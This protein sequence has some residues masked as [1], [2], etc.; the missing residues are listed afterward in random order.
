MIRRL[1]LSL[2][3]A[4]ALVAIAQDQRLQVF[5]LSQRPAEDL[6][7]AIRPLVGAG[8]A[9]TASGSKLIVNASP[10]AL[11]EIAR[12]VR[13]LDVPARSL[14]IT[15]ERQATG[16]DQRS[17]GEVSGRVDAG[18]VTVTRPPTTTV[19]RSGTSVETRTGRTVVTG[20]FAGGSVESASDTAFRIRALDGRPAFIAVGG[21]RPIATTGAVTN[22]DGSVGV[23]PATAIQAAEQGV[24]VT[25]RLSG[26]LVSLDVSVSADRFG[27]AGSV[28]RERLG[29][30]ASARLGEWIWLGSLS[31]SEESRSSDW[32]ARARAL[33][34]ELT[35]VRLRVEEI[36]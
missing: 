2:L 5:T 25:P 35:N 31:S 13:E 14:W 22:P 21:E 23:V 27:V 29:T 24:Y 3:L 1:L 12:L 20:A 10:A 30:T 36:R 7:E 15:V 8:G 28:V 19:T 16:S 4:P 26:D 17:A 32:L 9:V 18:G 33:R 34:E 11:A 6:V